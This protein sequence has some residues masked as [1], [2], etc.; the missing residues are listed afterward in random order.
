[1]RN[2][3]HF[4]GFVP[5]FNNHLDRNGKSASITR[6]WLASLFDRAEVIGCNDFTDRSSRISSVKALR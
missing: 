3:N 2:P 5:F 6:N 4:P 1:M